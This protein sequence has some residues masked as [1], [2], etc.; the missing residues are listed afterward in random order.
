M[1]LIEL[2]CQLGRVRVCI[3]TGGCPTCIHLKTLHIGMVGV[4]LTPLVSHEEHLCRYKFAELKT[5]RPVTCE[6]WPI[7]AS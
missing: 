7:Y 3:L 5:S 4:I 1:F 6:L 2:N